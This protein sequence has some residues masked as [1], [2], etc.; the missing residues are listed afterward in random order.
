MINLDKL[1]YLHIWLGT[2]KGSTSEYQ[3]LFDLSSFYE[4]YENGSEMCYIR[5]RDS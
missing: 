1:D 3:K 5:G 4:D 2:Y